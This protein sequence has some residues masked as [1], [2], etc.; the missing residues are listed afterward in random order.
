MAIGNYYV[1]AINLIH[2][3]ERRH[4]SLFLE[5][6]KLFSKFSSDYQKRQWAILILPIRT[7]RFNYFFWHLKNLGQVETVTK[8]KTK[9]ETFY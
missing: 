1:L 8:I 5:N 3:I 6:Y 4:E 2:K 9:K 7:R